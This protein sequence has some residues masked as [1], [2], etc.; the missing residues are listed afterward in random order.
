M[1]TVTLTFLL[2]NKGKK[3]KMSNHVPNAFE[4]SNCSHYKPLIWE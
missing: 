2:K 1:D 4:L 3:E